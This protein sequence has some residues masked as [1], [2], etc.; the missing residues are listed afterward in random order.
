[1]LSLFKNQF[2]LM[3]QL[4]KHQLTKYQFKNEST[5]TKNCIICS[6]P[7]ICNQKT[8]CDKYDINYK[9]G[10]DSNGNIDYGYAIIFP[11]TKSNINIHNIKL[12]ND[13]KKIGYSYEPKHHLSYS[14]LD[15]IKKID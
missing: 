14:Y 10:Y 7:T 1:M 9:I 5:S 2:K 12:Y 3:N 15:T 13:L 4:T 11:T 8:Y 6:T